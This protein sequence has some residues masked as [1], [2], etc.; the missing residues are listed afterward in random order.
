MGRTSSIHNFHIEEY[1]QC[2]AYIQRLHLGQ[3]EFTYMPHPK[4]LKVN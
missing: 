2:Q 1:I 3:T 4:Q